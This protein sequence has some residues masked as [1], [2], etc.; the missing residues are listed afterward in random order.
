ML[1]KQ[2][3]GGKPK[4]FLAKAV[5]IFATSELLQKQ[6]DDRIGHEDFFMLLMNKLLARQESK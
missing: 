1:G 2:R 5:E 3:E 4:F 6:R